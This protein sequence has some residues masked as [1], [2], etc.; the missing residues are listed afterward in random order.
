MKLV[1]SGKLESGIDKGDVREKKM[2]TQKKKK[3]P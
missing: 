2:E 1:E 3:K